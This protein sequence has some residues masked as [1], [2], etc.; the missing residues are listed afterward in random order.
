MAT[1]KVPP[2]RVSIVLY[3]RPGTNT[4]VRE[5]FNI[6]KWGGAGRPIR[7]FLEPAGP[8]LRDKDRTSNTETYDDVR[9]YDKPPYPKCGLV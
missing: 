4:Y 5:P 8:L 6:V 9:I 7:T 2:R 3:K 1:A